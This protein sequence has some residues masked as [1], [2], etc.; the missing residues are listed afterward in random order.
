MYMVGIFVSYTFSSALKRIDFQIVGLTW[1]CLGE[2]QIWDEWQTLSWRPNILSG[3]VIGT[4][5]TYDTCRIK[6]LLNHKFVC[7]SYSL[8]ELVNL[9]SMLLLIMPTGRSFGRSIK[10]GNGGETSHAF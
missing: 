2:I 3:F 8:T 1:K 4:M 7:H 9:D 10:D 6:N 5:T